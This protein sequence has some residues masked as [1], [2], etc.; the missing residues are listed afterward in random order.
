MQYHLTT[1]HG[2][3]ALLVLFD[4]GTT[5]TVAGTHPRFDQIATLM[6]GP[7]PDPAELRGLIDIGATIAA[8]LTQ[9]TDRIA[10]DGNTITFDGQVVD[11][12]ITRHLVRM[13]RSGDEQYRGLARFMQ[14]LADNPSGQSRKQLYTWLHERDMTIT[15][16][17]LFIGYKGVQADPEHHSINSGQATVNGVAHTGHIPNRTGALIQMPR[18]AVNDDRDNGCSTGLHVGTWQYASGFGARVLA[19][20]VNPRDVVSVPRDCDHQKLRTCRYRVLG[21]ITDPLTDTTATWA[22]RP[23]PV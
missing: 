4:D 11:T 6:L 16:S 12:A 20:L 15:P 8:T 9:L 18:S 1:D 19:I 7:D 5:A 17:G 21:P 22:D 2:H 10:V 13:V 14:N 3:R 23:I